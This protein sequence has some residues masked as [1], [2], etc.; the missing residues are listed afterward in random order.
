[1]WQLAVVAV[2]ALVLCV[3]AGGDT[4]ESDATL[5]RQVRARA[6]AN[7]NRLPDYTCL[8]TIERRIRAPQSRKLEL[9][10]VVRLEVALVSGKE[11]F[12][13]PGAKKFE[14]REISDLVPGGAIGNGSFALHLKSIFE[15][16]A[17]KFTFDG[18]AT[19]DGRRVYRWDFEVP[20]NRSAYLLRAG[21]RE[22]V[23]GYRGSFWVDANSLDLI[24]LEVEA[25]NIPPELKVMRAKDSVEYSQEK[26]GGDTF[27]LPSGSELDMVDQWNA[28]SLNRTRFSSCHQYQ[29]ESVISFGDPAAAATEAPKP[30]QIV[31]LPM[32]LVLE[33]LLETTISSD[34]A[35]VGDPVTA[36]LQ[37]ASKKHG[38]V[39]IPKGAVLHGH[40][41]M[42]RKQ[43]LGRTSYVLGMEF[44]EIEFPGAAARVHTVLDQI[45]AAD[46]RISLPN[47]TKFG[48]RMPAPELDPSLGSIVFIRGDGFKLARGLGMVW[49]TEPEPVAEE[50]TKK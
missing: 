6:A 11:L 17:P 18:E 2:G 36:V 29:G 46:G 25:E 23:V 28:E 35:A 34:T 45:A 26:I 41:T 39:M 47:T 21:G 50:K 1:M 38:A 30:V 33:V 20:R 9:Q 48:L 12:A 14:D 3:P 37:R 4:P 40:V 16:N 49:R 10:D 22:A 32:G 24:R 8:Q 5:L 7:L 13:W 19:R 42:L 44:D 15:T 43:N 31:E 27:L